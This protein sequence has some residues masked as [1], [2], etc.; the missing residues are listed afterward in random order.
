MESFHNTIGLRSRELLLQESK[1][2]TQEELILKFFKT[3]KDGEYT[4]F[5]I[6][7]IVF[8]HTIPITSV[9][10]SMTNLTKRELLIK[11]ENKKPGIYG[12]VNYTW[13]LKGN[14]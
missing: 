10:R 1:C 8:N 12:M 7:R 3:A 4:P 9:R 14:E 13:K 2:L 5:E 11:T 6:D